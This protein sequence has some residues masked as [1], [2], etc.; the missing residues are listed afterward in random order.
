M[1]T[2]RRSA[3]CH[4]PGEPSSESIAAIDSPTIHRGLLPLERM[5][6][7]GQKIGFVFDPH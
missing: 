1:R 3:L 6:Q 2:K 7:V 5:L 4:A